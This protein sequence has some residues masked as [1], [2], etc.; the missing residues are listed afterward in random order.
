MPT[1]T[2]PMLNRSGRHMRAPI[3]GVSLT[4]IDAA[5]ILGMYHRGDRQHDIA[6]YHGVDSAR[7]SEIVKGTNSAT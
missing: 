3:S 4:D 2:A 1:T 5:R 7:V 6:S